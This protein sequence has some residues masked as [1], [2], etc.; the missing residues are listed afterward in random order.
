MIRK[1]DVYDFTIYNKVRDFNDYVRVNI[2]NSIPSVYRDIRMHLLDECY[3]LVSLLFSAVYNKG[4][5]R[6]KYLID[7][8][9]RSY[10]PGKYRTFMNI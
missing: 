1:N 6:M 9:N 10:V 2:A 5:I 3:N 4:N 7:L 8:K